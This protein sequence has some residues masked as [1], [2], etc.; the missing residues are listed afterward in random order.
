[1][2]TGILVK[3]KDGRT[4][5]LQRN[6]PA[7]NGDLEDAFGTKS[8]PVLEDGEY[9]IEGF[10]PVMQID[11]AKNKWVMAH[12]EQAAISMGWP[13]R[14]TLY[15]F[16]DNVRRP[17]IK[18]YWIAP[19][20]A[21]SETPVKLTQNTEVVDFVCFTEDLLKLIAKTR[22]DPD[23]VNVHPEEVYSHMLMVLKKRY[24]ISINKK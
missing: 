19:A 6:L 15:F 5:N 2:S 11:D 20:E 1:M 14:N 17:G 8:T 12:D 10:E 13:T 21:A 16:K 24:N 7:I 4:I 3:V 18:N 9:P 22:N 23:F